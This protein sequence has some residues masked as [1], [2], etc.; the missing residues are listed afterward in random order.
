MSQMGKKV[1]LFLTS[2]IEPQSTEKNVN[3]KQI[4]FI[5]Q[6]FFFFLI[7]VLKT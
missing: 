1:N 2:I 7:A 6:F 4:H 3:I 5:E